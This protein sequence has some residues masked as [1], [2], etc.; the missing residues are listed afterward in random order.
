ML[1]GTGV[2]FIP[3]L[4]AYNYENAWEEPEGMMTAQVETGRQKVSFHGMIFYGFAQLKYN[5]HN[6]AQEIEKINVNQCLYYKSYKYPKDLIN[7]YP[8]TGILLQ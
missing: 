8:I 2:E 6:I 3:S 4:G 1:A 7:S 5:T